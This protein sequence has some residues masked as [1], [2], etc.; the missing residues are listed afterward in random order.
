MDMQSYNT[1]AILEKTAICAQCEAAIFLHTRKQISIVIY[2]V[3][4]L[5]SLAELA[6]LHQ[7]G[8]CAHCETAM[9]Q[10][11][12]ENTVDIYLLGSHGAIYKLAI[13]V[14]L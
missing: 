9:F 10:H 2:F 3:I 5:I 1:L 4:L 8:S 12:R 11:E 13:F 14:K 6:I 7:Q